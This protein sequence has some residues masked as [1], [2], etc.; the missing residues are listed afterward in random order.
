MR[1]GELLGIAGE[2]GC[3]KS[4]LAYAVTRMLKP[5]AR[6]TAGRVLYRDREGRRPTC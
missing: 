5:P 4:T 2:S 3:G 1:R 6:L